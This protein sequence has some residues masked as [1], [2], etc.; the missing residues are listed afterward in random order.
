MHNFDNRE[1]YLEEF[2]LED[3]KCHKFLCKDV[4]KMRHKDQIIENPEEFYEKT[5]E[6]ISKIKN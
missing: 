5:K 1:G 3:I 6:N 4:L 2:V